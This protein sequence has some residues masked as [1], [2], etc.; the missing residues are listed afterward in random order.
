[1]KSLTNVTPSAEQLGIIRRTRAGV[2]LIRGAAGSGKTTTAILK[3]KLLVLWVLARRKRDESTV[4]VKALVL[5]YNKTLKG[6]VK[7]LVENNTPAGPVEITV[8]TF[9]RW[10]YSTLGARQIDDGNRLSSLCTLAGPSI[11]LPGEFLLNEVQYILGR[12]HPDNLNDYLTQTRDGRGIVPRVDKDSRQK[13]FDEIIQPFN[14]YKQTSGNVDWNDIAVEM[15]RNRHYDYD[16]VII[17]EA[18]DFSA[19]QIRAVLAQTNEDTATNIVLDTAQRIYSNAFTWSEV[20]V[21]IRPENS[22]RLSVN[23]R[24]TP[25]IAHLAASLINCVLLD[26]DGT[27]PTLDELQGNTKPIILKSIFRNQVA[28]IIDHIKKNIDITKESIAFLHPKGWF[29]FLEGELTKAGIS[30]VTLTKQP[31]WPKSTINVALSTLHSAKGLDFDHCFM[32]GLAAENLPEGQYA[33]GDDR[34]DNA[35]RL[36]S[37]AIARA[38]M[39]VV[40]GYKPGEEPAILANLNPNYYDEI[41]L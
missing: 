14:L 34:F 2:E 25:E 18:Q 32:L 40:L 26:D 4:P 21:R 29:G 41:E 11:G 12:F 30:Y 7:E 33:M 8:D 35:C 16:I 19:N 31:E 5:T 39:S 22:H 1:M 9:A 36:L 23:Y 13:I 15:S 24:N 28:W 6:Y 38:R 27:P 37:M 3:L 17:D 10:A 20:G